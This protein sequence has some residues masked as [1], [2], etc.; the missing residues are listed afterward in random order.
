MILEGASD[1]SKEKIWN[2]LHGA[3]YSEHRWFTQFSFNALSKITK[4]FISKPPS[5]IDFIKVDLILS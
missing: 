3:P 1:I 4:S 5:F 2:Y